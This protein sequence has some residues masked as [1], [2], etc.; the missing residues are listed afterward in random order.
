MFT[1]LINYLKESRQEFKR[2][3]WPTRKETIRMTTTVIVISLTTA[4]FLG[5]LDLIFTYL[6]GKFFI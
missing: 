4:I 1:R 2:V 5:I 3:N 6:L